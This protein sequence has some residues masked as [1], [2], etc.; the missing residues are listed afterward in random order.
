MSAPSCDAAAEAV[1]VVLA[2]SGTSAPPPPPVAPPI[3]PAVVV[4][5]AIPPPPPPAR[6]VASTSPDEKPG[7]R[8]Y[9]RV[10]VEGALD[11]GTLPV[12]TYGARLRA[13]LLPRS[14]LALGVSGAVWANQLGYAN[15]S[16]Q[17]QGADFSLLTFDAFGCYGLLRRRT[18]ELSPCLVLELDR[19]SATGKNEDHTGGSSP[20]WVSLGI[21]VEGRWELT[22]NVG[23]T[24]ELQGVVPTEGQAFVI[25]NTA[26]SPVGTVH[27][28]SVLAGRA[29]FGP[30]VRF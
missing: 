23:L 21:G 24:L 20:V 17:G 4:L 27:A 2:L 14:D 8:P 28:T 19:M 30:E 13:A 1:A 25:T 22:R 26:G 15:V 18:L 3:A 16:T 9:V 10:A 7:R 6:P 5:P 11:L 29:Y 12:A